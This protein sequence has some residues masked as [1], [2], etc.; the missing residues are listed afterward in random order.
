MGKTNCVLFSYKKRGSQVYKLEWKFFLHPFILKVRN[1]LVY[2][3][4]QP[5]KVSL[6]KDLQFVTTSILRWLTVGTYSSFKIRE[7]F[8][9]ICLAKILKINLIVGNF[10]RS[11][12]DVHINKQLTRKCPSCRIFICQA[13]IIFVPNI[14]LIHFIQYF[15]F[16]RN[17]VVGVKSQELYH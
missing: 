1:S 12:I 6:S 16:W 11:H 13:L 10:H 2:L 9:E 4:K 8:L 15:N 5:R 17:A 14:S 7:H 3:L